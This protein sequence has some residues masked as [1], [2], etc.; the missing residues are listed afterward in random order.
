VPDYQSGVNPYGNAWRIVPDVAADAD[1]DTGYLVCVNGQKIEVGGTSAAAPL[2]A[3]LIARLNGVIGRK[4]GLVNGA[5]YSHPSALRGI[6][7]GNNG[8]YEANAEGGYSPTC[9]IGSPNSTIQGLL[10]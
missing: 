10:T 5:L 8:V 4:M 1:P 6:V 9:G 3:G 7:S 2:W